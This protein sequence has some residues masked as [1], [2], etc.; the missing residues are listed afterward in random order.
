M[1]EKNREKESEKAAELGELAHCLDEDDRRVIKAF[2][3]G[4]QASRKGQEHEK[5][6]E[7]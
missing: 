7:K 6:E 3:A 5:S 2:I 1:N 4:L